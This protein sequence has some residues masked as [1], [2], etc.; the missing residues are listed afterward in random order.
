MLGYTVTAWAISYP[1][2]MTGYVMCFL[3]ALAWEVVDFLRYVKRMKNQDIAAITH[4]KSSTPIPDKDYQI[5]VESIEKQGLKFKDAKC[6]RSYLFFGSYV[7]TL[8]FT[9]A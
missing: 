7:Y 9:K 2:T 4:M 1:R 6:R 3:I 8:R 5:I